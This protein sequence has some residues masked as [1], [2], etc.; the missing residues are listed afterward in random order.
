MKKKMSSWK[1]VGC[2]ESNVLLLLSPEF[3]ERNI[4]FVGGGGVGRDQ[5][6]KRWTSSTSVLHVSEII[7]TVFSLFTLH[8]TPLLFAFE[9]IDKAIKQSAGL[10]NSAISAYY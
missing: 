3:D 4:F 1:T 6:I 2:N 7:H 8:C 5:C 10:S 9:N